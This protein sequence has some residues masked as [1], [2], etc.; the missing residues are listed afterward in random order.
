M[1]E[2]YV[3][4]IGPD[5][6]KCH[7][8]DPDKQWKRGYSARTLAYCWEEANGF[9]PEIAALFESFGHKSELLLAIPEHKVPLPGA[10]RGESQND[11]FALARIGDMTF[12]ITVEGKVN[13]SFGV[14]LHAWLQ[15]ASEGKKVRLDYICKKLGLATL[16]SGEIYYQ[17]LHRAASAVIEAERF[18]TDSA[19]MIVHSFSPERL[20][21]PEF[22]R[23][24]SLFD[25]EVAPDHL[26]A[27]RPTGR[28]PL[29]I[30]W[31]CGD[32]HFLDA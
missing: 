27:V 28:P 3:P 11:L 15:D 31:A 23:F 9:P 22:A 8:A 7:L 13:E 2:I 29:Y 17:L 4:S 1:S 30:G 24:A 10:S 26:V 6:W 32:L 18:K 16:P 14:P 25:T 20:W 19:A 21:Y 12:A 5:D